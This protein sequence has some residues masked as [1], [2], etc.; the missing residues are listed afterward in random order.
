MTAL[1]KNR[2][3]NSRFSSP[4]YFLLTSPTPFLPSTLCLFSLSV[5]WDRPDPTAPHTTKNQLINL[6]FTV[7]TF[8]IRKLSNKIFFQCLPCPHHFHSYSL[9]IILRVLLESAVQSVLCA[10]FF[11]L[12]IPQTN[13]DPALTLCSYP[14]CDELTVYIDGDPHWLENIYT[15]W[16]CKGKEHYFSTFY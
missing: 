4:H 10:S 6:I 3:G 8:L 2:Y 14:F 16:C 11:I 9:L 12:F 7:R 1:P 5:G 15:Y 13:S